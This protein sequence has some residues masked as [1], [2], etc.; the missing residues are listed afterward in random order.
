[1]ATIPITLLY[2][3]LGDLEMTNGKFVEKTVEFKSEAS[4]GSF[5]VQDCVFNDITVVAH[6]AC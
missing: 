3:G 5:L 2:R 6:A 1:M 4:R